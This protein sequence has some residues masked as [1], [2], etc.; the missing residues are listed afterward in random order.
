MPGFER[1]TVTNTPDALF[2]FWL[3]RLKAAELR[4][5]LYAIRRTYGFGKDSDDISIEQFAHGITTENGHTLD[6]G[7]GV[8]RATVIRSLKSLVERGLLVKTLQYST[9]DGRPRNTASN[10]RLAVTNPRLPRAA[11]G[12][13]AINVTQMPDELFDYWLPR[14]SDPELYVLLYIVRRTLGFHKL[15]D[16]ISREQF[17]FGIT[18]KNGE[19][20]DEGCGISH[21]SLYPALAGLQEK[22]LIR[23][24]RRRDRIRGNM[25]SRYSLVFDNELPAGIV[26]VPASTVPQHGNGT[27]A[28]ATIGKGDDP[29]RFARRRTPRTSRKLLTTT[30]NAEE[31]PRESGS[32]TEGVAFRDRGGRNDGQRESQ[33]QADIRAQYSVWGR[34]DGQRGAQSRIEG[35]ATKDIEDRR[36][37]HSR[38]PGRQ[39]RV[40]APVPSYGNDDDPQ[41]SENNKTQQPQ[42]TA[43]QQTDQQDTD[44]IETSMSTPAARLTS[45]EGADLQ[46]QLR[47][48]ADY[49]D[50]VRPIDDIG[51]EFG[52]EATT[53]ASV[54]RAY[55]LM[56]EAEISTPDFVQLLYEAKAL[57]RVHQAG[58]VKTRSDSGRLPRKNLMPY[59]FATLES[60]LHPDRHLPRPPQGRR[61]RR[62]QSRT[63]QLRRDN[64]QAARALQSGLA[65]VP[66]VSSVSDMTSNQPVDEHPIWRR[67]L[68]ELSLVLTPENFNTWLK[69][70]WVV[71]ND[72]H[73][74]RIAVPKP[75][76]KDWLD[77]KLR[78]RIESTVRRLGYDDIQIEFEVASK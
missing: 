18:K 78:G 51:R 39:K 28:A 21:S 10:F 33:L 48:D 70:T 2:D 63:Q 31:P 26:E 43:D 72:G 34:N 38:S 44:T 3:P 71:G 45:R 59:F 13:R 23:I 27:L 41:E 55:N 46:T 29:F 15:S 6:E 20:L 75:F 4:V 30:G 68:D 56:R 52:D 5:L 25:P 47:V 22:G 7:C 74:L 69:H 67:V 57:T 35:D 64:L 76:H 60:L 1:P 24:E 49:Q 50:L 61:P 8:H 12:F 73:V 37:D 16:V 62:L 36:S 58:I 42:Q 11:H 40:A 9:D 66:E 53:R 32:Q 17:F 77:N 65:A 54:S 14:L 19:V